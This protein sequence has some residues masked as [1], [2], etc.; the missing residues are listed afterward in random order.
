MDGIHP[1]KPVNVI[2]M[3]LVPGEKEV[4]VLEKWEDQHIRRNDRDQSV[5]AAQRRSSS[6]HLAIR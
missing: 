1:E 5:P 2:E 3:Y 4:E 6:S